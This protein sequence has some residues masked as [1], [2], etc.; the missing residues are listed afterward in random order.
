MKA[1]ASL[2]F[3][4]MLGLL[5][6]ACGGGGETS[7]PMAAA[8][9]AP[10]AAIP[11]PVTADITLLMMGNSHTSTNGLPDTLAAMIHAGKPGK[12]VATVVAPGF[13][14]LDE[15]L[16]D[17]QSVA[18]LQS[19]RW[20]FVVL[21]AQKYSS[22]GLNVYSTTEAEQLIRMARSMGAVPIMFP[23]WPRLRI[24]ET[25]TIYNPHV[26]IAMR[27]AAC[28]APIGQAWDRALARYPALTLHAGD[29]NHSAPAGAFLAALVLYATI[30]GASPG[31]LPSL[32]VPG[33]DDATQGLLRAIATET[34]Q[35]VSPRRM[36]P[37]D[38]V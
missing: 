18:L 1:A 12:T 9:S 27:Q 32:P 25:Q 3:S 38:P 33:V 22:T 35:A 4:A 23:E 11:P 20:T 15:R 14:F 19:K 5:L 16:A 30:T 34:V 31:E 29:G 17:A 36:C 2:L 26:S 28:V 6:A 21:Q 24:D 7:V 10:P 13:M 37:N 8:P